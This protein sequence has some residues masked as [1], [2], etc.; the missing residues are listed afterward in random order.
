MPTAVA[1]SKSLRLKRSQKDAAPAAQVSQPR[2]IGSDAEHRNDLHFLHKDSPKRADSGISAVD[3]LARPRTASS[4]RERTHALHI[5]GAPIV[6]TADEQTY[7][8][9]TPSPKAIM[10]ARELRGE[11]TI[12]MAVG[13]PTRGSRSPTRGSPNAAVRNAGTNL[14]NVTNADSLPGPSSTPQTAKPKHSRWKSIFGRKLPAPPPQQPTPDN[15]RRAAARPSKESH[16]KG[17]SRSHTT[18]PRTDSPTRKGSRS[19]QKQHGTREIKATTHIREASKSRPELPR[20]RSDIPSSRSRTQDAND[21]PTGLRKPNPPPLNT[22]KSRPSHSSGRSPTPPPKD[23]S[24]STPTIP[25]FHMAA[26][27]KLETPEW[28]RPSTDRSPVNSPMLDVDIPKVELERYSVMFSSLL[29]SNRQSIYI[30]RQ[31]AQQKLKPL[32]EDSLRRADARLF[33][34]EATDRNDQQQ[35]EDEHLPSPKIQRRATSPCTPS[36]SLSLF[37]MARESSSPRPGHNDASLARAASPFRPPPP[38]RSNTAPMVLSPSQPT[39]FSYSRANKTPLTGNRLA[40]QIS[41]PSTPASPP[42]ASFD[43]ASTVPIDDDSSDSDSDS[44]TLDDDDNDTALTP[45]PSNDTTAYFEILNPS[46]PPPPVRS[47]TEPA[48]ACLR[49][50]VNL[51]KR[52]EEV[53][54]AAR[55]AIARQVSLSRQQAEKDAQRR[56]WLALR[57]RGRDTSTGGRGGNGGI[58]SGQGGSGK[59]TPSDMKRSQE[60]FGIGVRRVGT[61]TIVEVGERRSCAVQIWDA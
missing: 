11:R 23:R 10:E 31:G 43:S 1:R 55:M 29:N 20:S 18:A 49:G 41:R 32:N 3:E 28:P 16:S 5:K 14:A 12:G 33:T 48:P 35:H 38:K 50:P 22:S 53:Q 44:N 7:D 40:E 54:Q 2:Y 61:P 27:E 36:F 52:A 42:R 17:T 46:P 34:H 4:T 37:P 56:E 13:S 21:K 57:A 6:V 58:A 25:T 24:A 26:L 51:K 30:R 47:A 39:F 60:R 59:R 9:P 45:Q 19:A 8:F 15:A